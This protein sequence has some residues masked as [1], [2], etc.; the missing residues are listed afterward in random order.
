MR[1][2]STIPRRSRPLRRRHDRGPDGGIGARRIIRSRR[3]SWAGRPGELRHRADK[4]LGWRQELAVRS[5]S[6][7]SSLA[8]LLVLLWHLCHCV[9]LPYLQRLR[10]S[11]QQPWARS[12]NPN[13]SRY[14]ETGAAQ[15]SMI[16]LQLA[17]RT[18]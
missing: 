9:N 16:E 4:D 3:L 8:V 2:H 7:S 11:K 15:Q 12:L 1:L 18:V 14:V 5:P 17:S 13:S 10:H 6:P